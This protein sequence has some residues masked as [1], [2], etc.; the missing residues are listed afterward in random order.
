MKRNITITTVLILFV[1]ISVSFA[2]R[3]NPEYKSL[4]LRHAELGREINEMADRL[5]SINSEWSN[6]IKD[7]IDETNAQIDAMNF[8][9]ST[10]FSKKIESAFVLA[11]GGEVL[12]AIDCLLAGVNKGELEKK[13]KEYDELSY[14]LTVTPRFLDE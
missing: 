9:N 7:A 1:S 3:P 11:L 6:R 13:L 8:D 5:S 14:E 2:M 4:Y 10:K 12:R